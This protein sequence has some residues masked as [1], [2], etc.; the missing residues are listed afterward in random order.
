MRTSPFFIVGSPRSG[1]TLL[2]YVIRSHPALSLPTGESH[3]VVPLLRNEAAFGDLAN[4][5]NMRALLAEMHRRNGGFLD[6]DLHGIRFDI[7]EL[8]EVFVREGRRSVR[9]IFDA[10]MERNAHGE[11]KIRWGDKTP[12]YALH[13]GLLH[14]HWPDAQFIHLI[15][16]GRDVALSL[17]DREHDFRVYNSFSAAR[18]WQEYVEVG[19]EQGSKLPTG[20]YLEVRYEDL[21]SETDRT[22]RLICN[23]L[24][25]EF[26]ANM[27]D[28]EKSP[29]GGKTP[30][31]EGPLDPHNAGKWRRRMSQRQV[32]LF[33]GGAGHTLENFDYACAEPIRPLWLGTRVAMRWHNALAT[34][35]YRWQGNGRH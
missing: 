33:E 17:F 7:D 16:D 23:F 8:T 5:E 11:R 20:Q 27:T 6:T 10:L 13:I 15:R 25:V 26:V 19:H 22:L 30:L 12:Y 9:D 34:W 3:F 31:L 2:Q 29:D 32:Q 35:V 4:P 24:G 21:L 14:A 1:T 18:Y 28:Y